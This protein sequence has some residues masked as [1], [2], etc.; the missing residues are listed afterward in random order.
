VSDARSARTR[1]DPGQG[2][3]DLER[4]RQLARPFFELRPLTDAAAFIGRA[5]FAKAGRLVLSQVT[6]SPQRMEHEPRR[7]MGFDHRFLLFERYHDGCGRGLVDGEATR[8]DPGSMHLV[9]MS[10]HYLTMTSAVAAEGV[11]IPHSAVGYDPS[12]HRPY[13]SVAV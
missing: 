8:I 1:F 7:L 2:H 3:R 9:D 6:F 4:W 5:R 11:L 12:R 13:V 10:R